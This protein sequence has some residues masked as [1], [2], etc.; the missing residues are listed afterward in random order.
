MDEQKSTRQVIAATLKDLRKKAG[1]PVKDVAQRFG[2]NPNT[3]YAWEGGQNQ[4]DAETLLILCDLY[5]ADISDFYGLEPTTLSTESRLSA[6]E[7]ELLE[8]WRNA[9][10]NSKETVLE[11]LRCNQRP[12]KKEAEIS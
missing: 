10:D 3:V 1:I 9:T 12:M 2:I 4:P 5:H 11:V 6:D 7:A 8:L